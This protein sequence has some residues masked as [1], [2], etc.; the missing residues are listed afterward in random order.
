MKLKILKKTV[1][2]GTTANGAEY[3]MKS[4]YVVFT[5]EAVYNAIILHLTNR[6]ASLD[7]I[8]KFCS[9][10]E[11]NGVV[12]Y[13]FGL[14]CSHFTFDTVERFGI[15]DANIIFTINDRGFIGSKIK[16]VDRKEQVNGYEGP[17]DQVTGWSCGNPEPLKGGTKSESAEKTDIPNLSDLGKLPDG[18]ADGI[19]F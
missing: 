17:E 11:H 2:E 7:A 1:K 6:G 8:K 12:S 13:A 4:L 19:P 14:N 15:L 16:V 10:N 9:P 3:S 5:D 18:D